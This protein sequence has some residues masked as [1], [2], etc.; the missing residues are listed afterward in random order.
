V[1]FLLRCRFALFWYAK[2][3]YEIAEF[4]GGLAMRRSPVASFLCI[5]ITSLVAFGAEKPQGTATSS[6]VGSS[7]TADCR[8]T[9]TATMPLDVALYSK[10]KGDT[11]IARFTG[12]SSGL[13]VL[14]LPES[15]QRRAHVVTGTGNGGFALDGWVDVTAIPLF[16]VANLAVVPGHVWIQGGQRVEYDGRHQSHVRVQKTLTSP[17]AQSFS[18]LTSCSSL[19][20]APVAAI[21]SD[22]AR[23]AR[24][25]AFEHTELA[26]SNEPKGEP[27]FKLI[28]S[29][30]TTSV[31]LYGTD[32]KD[33]WVRVRYHGAIGLDAWIKSSDVRLLPKGERVDEYI[34]ATQSET[35]RLRIV[36]SGRVVS[37]SERVQVRA[38]PAPDA[39]VIGEIEPATEVLIMDVAAGWASVLPKALN[40]APPADRQ[41]WVEARKVGIQTKSASATG[42]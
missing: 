23:W 4:A 9:G 10:D 36:E 2:R 24:G 33:D 37:V 16:A 27:S 22:I 7:A 40:V 34:P 12:M 28:R 20:V 6:L 8:L 38:R 11:K 42:R 19:S 15:S 17:F 1:W 13:T 30:V 35:G 25:Y 39:G 26:L 31:F 18:A 32:K 21:P 41:F 5:L 29:S 14:E 3:T